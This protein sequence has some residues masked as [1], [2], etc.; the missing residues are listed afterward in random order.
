MAGQ[1][2]LKTSVVLWSANASDFDVIIRR[3]KNETSD[4]YAL[5]PS[6][7]YL[8]CLSLDDSRILSSTADILRSL[9]AKLASAEDVQRATPNPG[10]TTSTGIFIIDEIIRLL[11]FYGQLFGLK[12]AE[13]GEKIRRRPEGL[14][15]QVLEASSGSMTSS[16]VRTGLTVEEF[17]A[18]NLS[19]PN[20]PNEPPPPDFKRRLENLMVGLQDCSN[21]LRDN[22]WDVYRTAC[23]D[24][25]TAADLILTDAELVT[26]VAVA[27]LQVPPERDRNAEFSDRFR[28]FIEGLDAPGNKSLVEKFN[29]ELNSASRIR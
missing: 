16:I 9:P 11:E 25:L 13:R 28:A 5:T 7:S 12:N 8:S 18:L 17:Q 21:C 10:L 3:T 15:L 14:P 20:N 4:V 23:R 26:R 27:T 19:P 6:V 24:A 22:N 2:N 29:N 1:Y